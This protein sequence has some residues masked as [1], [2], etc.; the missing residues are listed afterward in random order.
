MQQS[1]S[2]F[3]EIMTSIMRI[4]ARICL[5]GSTEATRITAP[6]INTTNPQSALAVNCNATVKAIIEGDT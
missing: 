2:V 1:S 5:M 3:I 4:N 6:A